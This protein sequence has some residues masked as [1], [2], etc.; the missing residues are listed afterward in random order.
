MVEEGLPFS[1][2]ASVS[3]HGY[4]EQG[5]SQKILI[6]ERNWSRLCSERAEKTIQYGL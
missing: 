4:V 1:H 3:S 2:P 6:E 5:A